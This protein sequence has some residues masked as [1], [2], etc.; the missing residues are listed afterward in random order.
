MGWGMTAVAATYS[1]R[2]E[3]CE[4]LLEAARGDQRTVR[5]TRGIESDGETI[6]EMNAIYIY[7]TNA[8]R[9]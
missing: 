4:E 9:S 5:A 6:Y 2:A 7:E 3:R 1:Q 8:I